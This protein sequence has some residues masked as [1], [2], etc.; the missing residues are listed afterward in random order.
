MAVRRNLG[1]R[2]SKFTTAVVLA[3]VTALFQGE[4][5]EAAAKSAGVGLST[6]YRW[7]DH[8][9]RGGPRFSPMVGAVAQSSAAGKTVLAYHQ[10]WAK[11]W[12]KPWKF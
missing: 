4:S 10:L 9:R 1:G 11:L 2:P 12:A 5:L 3:V 8:G 7:L 6:V